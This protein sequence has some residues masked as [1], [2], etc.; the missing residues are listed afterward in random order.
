M[1]ASVC[2][3]FCV[4][5]MVCVGQSPTAR[6]CSGSSR[7]LLEPRTKGLDCG[8]GAQA[9]RGVA[10]TIWFQAMVEA[11]RSHGATVHNPAFV[12]DAC[13]GFSGSSTVSWRRAGSR[14]H[15]WN[16]DWHESVGWAFWC[17][18]CSAC[19]AG[20]PAHHPELLVQVPLSHWCLA[21][22]LPFYLSS[23]M[24]PKTS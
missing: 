17:V 4:F 3:I 19:R 23:A 12:C 21:V 16:F 5:C 20:S 13:P 22:L 7:Q 6:F 1:W 2:S 24:R 10:L 14:A 9:G 8:R 18:P 15:Y 11:C